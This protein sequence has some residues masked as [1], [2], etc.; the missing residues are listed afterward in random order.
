MANILIVDDEVSICAAFSSFL[1]TDGHL[2]R[3]ASSGEDAL[4]QVAENPPD[5]VILDIRLPGITGL[6]ALAR[7]RKMQPAL[8]VVIITAHGTMDNAV[9]AMQQGAY[10]YLVKPVDLAHAREVVARALSVSDRSREV[11]SHRSNGSAGHLLVGAS[12]A[13]QAVYKKIGMAGLSD[14]GVLIQGESGTGKELAAIAI[15]QNSLRRRGAFVPINCGSLPDT[16]LESELFG[17]E[18]GAFTGAS[19]RKAGRIE[20]ADGGTLFLD[21]I[22][23][24]SPA[25]QVKLLRFLEDKKLTRL[26][27]VQAIAVDAR[28]IA[29][30]NQPVAECV[31]DG[32][33]RE[34]LYYRLNV[35]SIYLPPLRERLADLPALVAHFLDRFSGAARTDISPQALDALRGY[36]WPGNVR[37]LRNAIEHAAVAARGRVIGIEHL[38]EHIF[39]TQAD[40]EITGKLEAAIREFVRERLA[41]AENEGNVTYDAIMAE[42]EKPV[43]RELMKHTSSN[44]A[45]AS[46]LLSIHRTTLRK[47]LEELLQA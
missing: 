24:M 47:K 45:Y 9:E 34:D 29:A 7:M 27:A 23:E 14:A 5:L 30:T 43:L 22:A 17:Y 38:P 11:E 15:H 42:L 2:P 3:V 10:E 16:L 32:S 18:E 31:A 35:L 19:K 25:A 1:K 44:Q 33:F 46:R 20:E 36:A 26:G 21:E 6:Q 41:R 37:E 39:V 12:P 8:P 28:V 13:M 4:R 40:S